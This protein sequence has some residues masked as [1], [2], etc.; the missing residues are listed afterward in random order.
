MIGLKQ[1]LIKRIQETSDNDVLN[2]VYR[3]LGL[4]FEEQEKYNLTEEQK[5]IISESKRQIAKGDFLTNE[6]SKE[7]TEKWLKEK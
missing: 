4:E 3:L 2:E 5:S 1:K 7:A 6:Q